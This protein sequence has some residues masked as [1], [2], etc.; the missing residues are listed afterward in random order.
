M[1]RPSGEHDRS[2]LAAGD[3]DLLEGGTAGMARWVRY[4]GAAEFARRS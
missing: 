2:P 1:G 4:D 3:T